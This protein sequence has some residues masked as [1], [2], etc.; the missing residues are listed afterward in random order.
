MKEI[1]ITRENDEVVA[2]IFVEDGEIRAITEN[3]LK[4]I[5]DGVELDVEEGG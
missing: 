5:V 1:T 4:V 3:G 2:Y